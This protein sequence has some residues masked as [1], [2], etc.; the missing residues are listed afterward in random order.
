MKKIG[1]KKGR[2]GWESEKKGCAGKGGLKGGVSGTFMKYL[3][4]EVFFACYGCYKS[5]FH[6]LLKR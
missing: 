1:S 3:S 5:D 4:K 2:L 6:D